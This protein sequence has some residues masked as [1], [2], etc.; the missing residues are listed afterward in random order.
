MTT[1]NFKDKI[2]LSALEEIFKKVEINVIPSNNKFKEQFLV[3]IKGY[4]VVIKMWR[5]HS[6]QCGMFRVDFC[7]RSVQNPHHLEGNIFFKLT[8]DDKGEIQ[9]Q[10]QFALTMIAFQLKLQEYC[11]SVAKEE[12]PLAEEEP[13][14]V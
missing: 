7:K 11:I 8:E 5:K 12:F 6:D 14:M 4:P 3:E 13:E 2:D 10:K 9:D 1:T